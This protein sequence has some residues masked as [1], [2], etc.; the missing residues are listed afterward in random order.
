MDES[1]TSVLAITGIE[2]ELL[3]EQHIYYWDCAG[4]T[5]RTAYLL[6]GLSRSY[7]KNRICITGI[8]QELLQEQYVY[9]W[10]WEGVHIPSNS[11]SDLIQ[12]WFGSAKLAQNQGVTGCS[13][14]HSC[15]GW[16]PKHYGDTAFPC[17]AL[18]SQTGWTLWKTVQLI[19]QP[20]VVL[21]YEAWILNLFAVFEVREF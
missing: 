20:R 7:Y 11:K 16:N 19:T 21:S 3:Q 6:L 1:R 4:V 15:L 14:I 13:R 17:P 9:Y 12:V 2:Q 18:N 5:T 8:E 10:E